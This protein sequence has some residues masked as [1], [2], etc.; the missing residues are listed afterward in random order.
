[1]LFPATTPWLC[2]WLRDA[3]ERVGGMGYA[4]VEVQ[5]SVTM[6]AL[7]DRSD[8]A[9]LVDV[10]GCPPQPRLVLSSSDGFPW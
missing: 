8:D 3:E 2:P 5:Q 1:M 10:P 9:P 6:H 4:V 7:N